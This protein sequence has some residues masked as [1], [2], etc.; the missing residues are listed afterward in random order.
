MKSS[1][2]SFEIITLEL[3]DDPCEKLVRAKF[4]QISRD[5][6]PVFFFQITG[7][8]GRVPQENFEVE[9]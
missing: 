7:V 3:G 6:Y 9:K 8:W 2:S 1:M 5:F 4:F